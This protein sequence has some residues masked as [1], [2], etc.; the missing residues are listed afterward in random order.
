MDALGH[1]S[2]L[3]PP[4]IEQPLSSRD[5]S[6]MF[7]RLSQRPDSENRSASPD[8]SGISKKRN[9]QKVGCQQRCGIA[10]ALLRIQTE[11]FIRP[12]LH[13]EPMLS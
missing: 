9:I 11:C 5:S 4:H 12:F 10:A 1:S 7:T 6:A 3:D 13:A 8:C 2:P